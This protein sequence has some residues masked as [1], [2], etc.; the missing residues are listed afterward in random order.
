MFFSEK[1][2]KKKKKKKKERK[3]EKGKNR[4]SHQRC[5]LKKEVLKTF[6]K[7]RGK[8]LCQSLFSNKIGT[9]FTVHL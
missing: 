5:F 8:H 9:I 2:K 3:K 1:K 7:F 4:S 6:A